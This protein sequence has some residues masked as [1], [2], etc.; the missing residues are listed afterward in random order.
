PGVEGSSLRQSTPRQPAAQPPAPVRLDRVVSA[1]RA[2]LSGQV[3]LG[4]NAPRSNARLLFVSLTRG[5]QPQ[6]ATA[7]GWGRFHVTLASGGWLVYVNDAKDK[8]V[9]HSKIDMLERDNRQVTLVA[10]Q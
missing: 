1:S 7:D 10:R 2:D 6:Y 9:F 8:P 4:N 3:V 5:A